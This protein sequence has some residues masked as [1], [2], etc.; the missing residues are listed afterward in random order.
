[1]SVAKAYPENPRNLLLGSVKS[2]PPDLVFYRFGEGHTAREFIQPNS[3]EI[4]KKA[5]EFIGTG[6]TLVEDIERIWKG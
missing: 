5:S 6:D 4:Q 1:M 2:A 3:Y